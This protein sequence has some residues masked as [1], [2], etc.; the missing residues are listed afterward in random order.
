[1][2]TAIALAVADD[3]ATG[4]VYNVGEADA[5]TEAEWVEGIVTNPRLFSTPYG[6]A[7]LK[8]F[9]L[10]DALGEAG[11]LK[12]LRLEGY[13]TRS[14]RRPEALQQALFPYHEAWGSRS[15]PPHPPGRRRS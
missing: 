8:L 7:Q 2:A 15:L 11:W 5:P 6:A 4:R 13:A 14:R 10:E 1:M 3:R 12:G 9:G